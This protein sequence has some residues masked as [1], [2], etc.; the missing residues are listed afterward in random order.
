VAGAIA[1]GVAHDEAVVVLATLL[2][3]KT[4]AGVT[5]FGDIVDEDLGYDP[6]NQRQEV[7]D[8][9]VVHELVALSH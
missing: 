8:I 4:V 2:D 9:V 1:L 3:A 5:E 6:T 7:V